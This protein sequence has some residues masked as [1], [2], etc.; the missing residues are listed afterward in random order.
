MDKQPFDETVVGC[1]TCHIRAAIRD[2][3]CYACAPY[4][5]DRPAWSIAAD[6]LGRIGAINNFMFGEESASIAEGLVKQ[7]RARTGEVLNERD[8]Y[9][10]ALEAIDNAAPKTEPDR[11]NYRAPG[12]QVYHTSY[13]RDL[14]LYAQAVIARRALGKLPGTEGDNARPKA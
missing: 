6:L 3:L 13:A 11:D 10:R 12:G 2:G 14:A 7:L 1:T 4:R 8:A 5:L 9:R